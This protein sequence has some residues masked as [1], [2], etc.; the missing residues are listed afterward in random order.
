MTA[1]SG[2]S[3]REV[4][5]RWRTAHATAAAGEVTFLRTHRY[6]WH[7]DD[8]E[9]ERALADWTF[10]PSAVTAADLVST[11]L[12]FG[13]AEMAKP[14]AAFLVSVGT[15]DVV[16]LAIAS[17]L[18]TD[19]DKDHSDGGMPG[20]DRNSD[21]SHARARL[22]HDRQR[23][24]RDPRN[25]LAWA[26]SALGY[27]ILGDGIRAERA[28]QRGLALAPDNRFMLRSAARLLVH[29]GDPER[30][31]KLLSTATGLTRD[32]WLLAAELAVAGAAGRESEFVRR[33]QELY[34][35][36]TYSD[37]D[38]SELGAALGTIHLK[39]GNRK[40]S[41]NYFHGGLSSPT[42]N[43]VAQAEWASEQGLGIAAESS[44]SESPQAFEARARRATEEADWSVALIESWNWY[45]DQPFASE[46]AIRGSY[47]ASVGL[48]DF[49][50]AL[51]IA[52]LGLRANPHDL[53]LLN[54]YAFAAIELGNYASA[55]AKLDFAEMLKPGE[56]DQIYLTATRG[57][58]S[59][60]LGDHERGRQQYRA[61]IVQARASRDADA[62][63]MATLRLVREEIRVAGLAAVFAAV[64][65]AIGLSK[66]RHHSGVQTELDRLMKVVK[67]GRIPKNQKTP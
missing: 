54:N 13:R 26:D 30:A 10:D 53:T 45:F 59:F 6:P 16:L 35:S 25:P 7:E 57:L 33:G 34:R 2:S 44:L 32:P 24:R 15:K 38:I 14:P 67:T 66:G 37:R 43:A 19:P 22:Q 63:A 4:I 65:A 42:E 39:A 29:R 60:R 27:A 64:R 28:M 40:K 17:A 49:V 36:G 23:L 61:A 1:A 56:R 55:S 5:P 48:E 8:A 31:H 58:M 12:V 9:F 20:P 41:R 21:E 51:N 47:A 62:Q 11:S 50:S 46:P 52:Q 3:D 18:I